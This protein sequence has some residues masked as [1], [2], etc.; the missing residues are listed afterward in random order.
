MNTVKVFIIS[1]LKHIFAFKDGESFSRCATLIM[2]TILLALNL[3]APSIGTDDIDKIIN[4]LETMTTIIDS[5]SKDASAMDSVTV[6]K[7][8]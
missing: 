1:F 7:I 8:R 6:Q 2:L 3:K 4:T 5:C